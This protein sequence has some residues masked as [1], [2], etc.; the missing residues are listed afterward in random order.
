MGVRV[1]RARVYHCRH[2]KESESHMTQ[3]RRAHEV[4]FTIIGDDVQLVESELDPRE[5]VIAEAGAMNYTE[6]EI[7][8]EAKLGDCSHPDTGLTGELLGAGKRALTETTVF[9]T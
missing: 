1:R 4:D 5:T 8:F 3:T 2:T 7:T 6:D 9:M